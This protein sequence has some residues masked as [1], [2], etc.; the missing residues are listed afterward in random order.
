MIPKSCDGDII[1][2]YKSGKSTSD[3][4]KVYNISASTVYRKVAAAGVVRENAEAIRLAATQG[5]LGS[6][7][8]GKKRILTESHIE[9]IREG[10][11]KWGR[12]NGKG[13]RVTSHNYI[14]YTK[15]MFKGKMEHVIKMEQRIGRP[16]LPDEC[17]HHIDGDRQNNDINNL[18]LM[19]RAAHSRL[20]RR[21]DSLSGVE[22]ERDEL[23]RFK[24]EE[25]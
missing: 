20:H 8:R 6:G 14:E 2:M 9:K 11:A 7:F 4:A 10:R 23:G 25:K 13:Y 12:E 19:T 5:K 16:I 17:V 3:I 1:S 15:G 24:G 22:K 21:E 18:A